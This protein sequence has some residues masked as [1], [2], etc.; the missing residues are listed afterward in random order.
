MGESKQ[1]KCSGETTRD[2][3]WERRR[4]QKDEDGGGCR[5]FSGEGKSTDKGTGERTGEGEVK[6]IGKRNDGRKGRR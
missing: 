2:Q 3:L 5:R 6:G 4:R 1:I